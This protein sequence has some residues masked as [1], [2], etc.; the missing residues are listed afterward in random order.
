MY[1]GSCFESLI[2]LLPTQADSRCTIL[3]LLRLLA[4]YVEILLSK[5]SCSYLSSLRSDRT[6][7]QSYSVFF[8]RPHCPF[9]LGYPLYRSLCALRLPSEAQRVS[10][11]AVTWLFVVCSYYTMPFPIYAVR[12][13]H[14]RNIFS[15]WRWGTDTDAWGTSTQARRY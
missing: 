8:D 2:K 6:P 7:S 14:C 11:E 5:R 15:K 3:A 12:V 13:C 4:Q 10:T 9:S 1:V